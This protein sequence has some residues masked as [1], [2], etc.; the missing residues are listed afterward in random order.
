[1]P[2]DP[3]FVLNPA[4]GPISVDQ[5]IRLRWLHRPRVRGIGRPPTAP[6]SSGQRPTARVDR[7]DMTRAHPL[8]QEKGS[9][10]AAGA[11]SDRSA[12]SPPFVPSDVEKPGKSASQRVLPSLDT[13]GRGGWIG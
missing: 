2:G 1:M 12:S 9:T 8:S 4:I 11:V 3:G 5:A 7:G 13:I 10:V 6:R